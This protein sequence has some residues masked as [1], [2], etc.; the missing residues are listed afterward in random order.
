MR[1]VRPM[2]VLGVGFI[3]MIS[4]AFYSGLDCPVCCMLI[5]RRQVSYL[6]HPPTPCNLHPTPNT[7]HPTPY[8]Q[9]PQKGDLQDGQPG[10]GLRRKA[11]GM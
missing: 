1:E 11:I 9:N 4:G 7:L 6:I 5:R 10:V 8:S 3:F 2:V